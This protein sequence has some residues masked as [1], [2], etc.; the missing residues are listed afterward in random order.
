MREEGE[1][2]PDRKPG[3]EERAIPELGTRAVAMTSY[4]APSEIGQLEAYGYL[5]Y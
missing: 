2:V 1:C 3:V 5:D 4:L